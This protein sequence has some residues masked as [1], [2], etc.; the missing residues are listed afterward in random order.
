MVNYKFLII[1]KSVRKALGTDGCWFFYHGLA[2]AA[3]FISLRVCGYELCNLEPCCR[4][5]L[6]H[7]L[8]ELRLRGISKIENRFY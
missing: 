7:V 5:A 3:N 2:A 8:R 4:V 1:F 6:I